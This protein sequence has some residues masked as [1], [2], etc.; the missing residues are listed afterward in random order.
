MQRVS[1]I[2]EG[3]EKRVRMANLA[4]VGTHSTNGV[5][6]IHSRLLRTTVVSD[7]AEIFPERFNNKTNGVTPRRWLLLANPDLARLITSAIGTGWITDLTQ[8]KKIAPLADD[9]A[10][11]EGFRRAKHAAKERFAA[12]LRI[13]DRAG[14]RPPFH[15][16]Y[17]GQTHSRIQ[18]PTSKYPSCHRSL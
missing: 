11:R 13:D 2:A 14:R 12:W 17:P 1:L 3:P 7:L 18:T 10:F 5:A 8:L 4:I 6:E 15:L 16:R 9:P